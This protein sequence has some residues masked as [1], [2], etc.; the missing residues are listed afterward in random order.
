MF[1]ISAEGSIC[2]LI[3]LLVIQYLM[4]SNNRR[5][6][7]H[8]SFHSNLT[9]NLCQNCDQECWCTVGKRIHIKMHRGYVNTKKSF[10]SFVSKIY[11][12]GLA[13]MNFVWGVTYVLTCAFCVTEKI[14]FCKV[15]VT[16][17]IY[18]YIYIER[19]REREWENERKQIA[20]W[21]VIIELIFI[22]KK[23]Q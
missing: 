19:E 21:K 12:T 6:I 20:L 13:K 10:F 5:Q 14:A 4:T 1:I 8:R 17:N 11:A 2:T 23:G 15:S 7:L 18:I 9:G 16:I 22:Q 3:Y